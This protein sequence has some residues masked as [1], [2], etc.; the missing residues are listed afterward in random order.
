RFLLGAVAA[1]VIAQEKDKDPDKDKVT[2]KDK[3]KDKVTDKDKGNGKQPADKAVL[4]VRVAEGAKLYIDG[5]LMSR[6]TGTSRRFV[7]DPMRPDAQFEYEL[8]ATWEDREGKHSATK[9]ILVKP[10]KTYPVDLTTPDAKP[11]IDKKPD[12]KPDVKPDAK[13]DDAKKKADAAKLVKE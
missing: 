3:D 7:S 6:P 5:T 13:P 11:A 1:A 12:V 4:E 8:K 10:G 2:D 9:K